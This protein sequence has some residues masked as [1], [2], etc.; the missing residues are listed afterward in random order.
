MRF[1]AAVPGAPESLRQC[2][3]VSYI[4]DNFHYQESERRYSLRRSESCQQ[5]VGGRGLLRIAGRVSYPGLVSDYDPPVWIA[6]SASKHGVSDP[7]MHHAFAHPLHV[8]DLDDS[9]ALLIGPD[10]AGNLLELVALTTEST[11]ILI[12]AMPLRARYRPLLERKHQ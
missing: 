11:P 4:L 12:H 2:P 5:D 9:K 7:D 6:P 8:S 1:P 10:R 3:V